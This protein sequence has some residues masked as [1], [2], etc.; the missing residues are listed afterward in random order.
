LSRRT[1][2]RA[3]LAG[4]ATAVAAWAAAGIAACYDPSLHDCTV[5]C[6]TADDCAG[7]QVCTGGLCVSPGAPSCSA[8]MLGGV[9]AGS[10]T[11]ID[12]GMMMPADAGGP[13]PPPGMI[14]L[15]VMVDGKGM[16]LVDG[17]GACD[18]QGAQHGDC[19]FMVVA[20]AVQTVHA[21][22]D[23]GSGEVFQQWAS[24]TCKNMT[25]NCT[26]TPTAATTVQAKFDKPSGGP[27]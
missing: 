16:I 19:T 8:D 4:V 2:W 18:S 20:N 23:L 26:F 7:G 11:H 9:D 14:A 17:H 13:P 5:S 10:A 24:T 6:S 22:A 12:A 15:H 25:A 21:I 3:A 27:P 1:G